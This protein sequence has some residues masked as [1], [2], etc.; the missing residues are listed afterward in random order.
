M[1]ISKAEVLDCRFEE[2]TMHAMRF[3]RVDLSGTTFSSC[4]FVDVDFSEAVALRMRFEN[5]IFSDA[6]LAKDFLFSGTADFRFS[7]EVKLEKKPSFE[8]AI[9]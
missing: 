7:A 2:C 1:L 3:F 5:C 9:E 8:L 6:R 4:R